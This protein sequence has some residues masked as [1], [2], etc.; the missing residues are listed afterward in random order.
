MKNVKEVTIVEMYVS[1][2][3]EAIMRVRN[4]E[5]GMTYKGDDFIQ[6]FGG[7]RRDFIG[8]SDKIKIATNPYVKITKELRTALGSNY[9]I[10]D[11]NIKEP[12]VNNIEFLRIEK[13][14]H[15]EYVLKIVLD[16]GINIKM[17]LE[18]PY[19]SLS[20]SAF[21]NRILFLVQ[22]RYN[23]KL[24]SFGDF[25][26][27]LEEYYNRSQ[28]DS[29]ITNNRSTMSRPT[30]KQDGYIVKVK[31]NK[32][33]AEIEVDDMDDVIKLING[34]SGDNIIKLS[35]GRQGE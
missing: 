2:I 15:L 4:N 19:S 34:L 21:Y 14:G 26:E 3:G 16:N 27:D 22:M 13:L 6:L 11:K 25:K 20:F 28:N 24:K 31:N 5:K 7:L 9:Y 8:N 10:W 29:F 12:K 35:V 1:S 17:P 23:I 18:V 32:L 30:S 33:R